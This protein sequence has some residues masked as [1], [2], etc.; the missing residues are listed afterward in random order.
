MDNYILT[1]YQQI[2]AG[3]VGVGKW[4]RLLMEMIVKGLENGDFF[5]NPVSA[6]HAITWIEQHC[7]HTEGDL[8]PSRLKLELWQKAT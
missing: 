5:Y 6:G 4:I 1:Y 7:F 8:A 2:R 3:A